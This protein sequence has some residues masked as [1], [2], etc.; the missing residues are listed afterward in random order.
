MTLIGKENHYN[1][2]FP[3]G[4]GVSINVKNNHL[5]LINGQ[6]DITGISDKEEWFISKST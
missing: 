6:N 3:K 5:I 2:K 1:V 4:Y